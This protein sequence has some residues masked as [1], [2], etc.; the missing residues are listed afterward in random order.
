MTARGSRA[1]GTARTAPVPVLYRLAAGARRTLRG[2]GTRFVY[3]SPIAAPLRRVLT[4]TAPDGACLVEICGGRLR[5]TK[6]HIDLACE[7]YYWLGTHEEPVQSML[8]ASVRPGC[9][10]Y[11][12]GAHAGFFS[13]LMSR[14]AGPA[15]RVIAF[16]P[17]PENVARLRAN[18][19]A[20]DLANIEAYTLAIS[21]RAGEAQFSMHASSLEGALSDSA[22]DTTGA[23]TTV[24]TI[25]IDELVRD[26]MPAPDLMKIDVEGAEGAVLRGARRTVGVHM[27][28]IVIE[29]HTVEA[30]REVVDALPSSYRFTDA[31]TRREVAPPLAARHYLARAAAL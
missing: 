14:L 11:D 15:G 17:V 31:V 6:M 20:N 10:A 3:G 5:G 12:I 4:T 22:A 21:D 24:R 18:A 27:P 13:L 7:K 2:R 25:T 23:T 28:A 1:P 8:A 29:I 16:D 26:G 30:A 9:V 19:D